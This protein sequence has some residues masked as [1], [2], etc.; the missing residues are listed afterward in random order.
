MCVL[1]TKQKVGDLWLVSAHPFLIAYPFSP[2]ALSRDLASTRPATPHSSPLISQGA[3]H[4]PSFFTPPP[5]HPP[6]ALSLLPLPTALSSRLPVFSTQTLTQTCTPYP[7]PDHACSP[8]PDRFPPSL[9]AAPSIMPP[10]VDIVSPPRDQARARPRTAQALKTFQL[11]P[12]PF[13]W[14][15][16]PV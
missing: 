15:L 7:T 5:P 11:G 16:P 3:R 1:Y 14:G 13:I 4:V 8:L 10:G 12:D 6:H 2:A 9:R